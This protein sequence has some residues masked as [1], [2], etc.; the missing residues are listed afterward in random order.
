MKASPPMPVMFG[1]VTF[2]TAA[3]AMAASTA[4]PPRFS[5]SRPACDASGWLVATIAWLARTTERPA[6]TRENQSSGCCRAGASSVM[7]HTTATAVAR[8]CR[9]R[10]IGHMVPSQGSDVHV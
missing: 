5:M 9:T 8:I 7:K 3:I 2:R 4:L 10:S 1:S 6:G